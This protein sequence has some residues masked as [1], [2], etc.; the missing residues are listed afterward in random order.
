[1]FHLTGFRLCSACPVQMGHCWPVR[2]MGPSGWLAEVGQEQSKGGLR[3]SG[4]ELK[5]VLCQPVVYRG[6]IT[7]TPMEKL[8]EGN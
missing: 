1:M 6:L 4:V 7:Q 5:A 3:C 2:Y 8:L